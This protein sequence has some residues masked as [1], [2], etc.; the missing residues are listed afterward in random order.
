MKLLQIATLIFVS[1]LEASALAKDNPSVRDFLRELPQD[2]FHGILTVPEN[3]SQPEGRKIR[4]FYYGRLVSGR[5]P[6]LVIPGG[7]AQSSHI[8][9]RR[10]LW[11]SV[12]AKPLS[13]IFFDPRGTGLSSPYPQSEEP[14]VQRLSQY[15]SAQIVKDLEALRAM[16][17]GQKPWRIFGHSYGTRV[18]AAYLQNYP[19]SIE[20]AFGSGY[21]FLGPKERLSRREEQL[22]QAIQLFYR[23]YPAIA[24]TIRAAVQKN[25]L[26]AIEIEYLGR[27]YS[28][29][30]ILDLT[31]PRFSEPATWPTLAGHLRDIL[32]LRREWNREGLLNI[33]RWLLPNG[34]DQGW[35]DAIT[36]I[37]AL[38]NN[39]GQTDLSLIQQMPRHWQNKLIVEARFYRSVL[40]PERDRSIQH[41]LLGIEP[42]VLSGEKIGKARKKTPFLLYQGE[43]DSLAGLQGD[44]K[45]ACEVLLEGVGHQMWHSQKLLEDLIKPVK[46]LITKN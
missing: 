6:V 30:Q 10:L 13:L 41:Q 19:K 42:N 45:L 25:K 17:L 34:L 1:L 22:G 15:T 2:V 3:W 26:E 39:E 7:P 32:N 46:D 20:A 28:I 38:D 24:Q 16:L 21:S 4:I 12:A 11:E 9:G 33:L 43:N 44:S 27:M 8:L 36:V 14:S 23:R 5:P 18:V 37:N 29:P 40:E 35:M 31:A